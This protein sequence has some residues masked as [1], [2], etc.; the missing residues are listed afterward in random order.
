MMRTTSTP[1]TV[2]PAITPALAALRPDVG[3]EVTRG[4]GEC[5]VNV[6]ETVAV[7]LRIL[8]TSLRH[9]VSAPLAIMNGDDTTA[10]SV[11]YA[12]TTYWPAVKLTL[13]QVHDAAAASTS[14][15]RVVPLTVTDVPSWEI[16]DT[17]EARK[18]RSVSR[19]PE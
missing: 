2:P 12:S 10:T 16:P 17:V 19:G 5:V 14:I 18:I 3:M 15:A 13:D 9:E 11:P 8:D 4:S 7:P 1:A 6:A